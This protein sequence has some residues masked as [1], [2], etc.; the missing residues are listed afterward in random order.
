M[1]ED[2]MV[3][4]ARRHVREV[5]SQLPLQTRMGLTNSEIEE[6]ATICADFATAQVE[7]YQKALREL[8]DAIECEHPESKR[9][10]DA[11]ADANDLLG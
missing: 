2:K 5:A 4:A 10:D 3:E 8:V 6:A 7:P 11:M 1:A 9:L